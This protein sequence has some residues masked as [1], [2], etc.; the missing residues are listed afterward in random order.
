[1]ARTRGA[2]GPSPPRRRDVDSFDR[3][4]GSYDSDWRSAFHSAVVAGGAEVALEA[5]PAPNAVLDIGCGTGAL[6]RTLATRL[7]S[8]ATLI[9]IDPAP[10]MIEVARIEVGQATSAAVR[11][12]AA[13]RPRLSLALATAER[14]PFADRS[15]DLVV[16][17]VSFD[18]WADQPAGLAEVRRVLRPEGR[19]VLVDLF[20]TGCLLPI[21]AIGRRR[22]RMRTIRET[23]SML[24]T[25][26]LSP[27]AWRP[28]YDLGPVTLV[29]AVIASPT[30]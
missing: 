22:D 6:L 14:L 27:L 26:W 30:T 17:T 25:A 19:L 11:A 15:F 16:T 7:R 5:V 10:T 4:A 23:G 21:A 29:H 24:A 1:M 12:E 8:Q 3:R 20:A 18:H 2:G 13:A 9:G 28:V